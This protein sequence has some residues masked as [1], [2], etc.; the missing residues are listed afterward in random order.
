MS[1]E[2]QGSGVWHNSPTAGTYPCGDVKSLD[3]PGKS[4]SPITYKTID[5]VDKS[6]NAR[7]EFARLRQKQV[8]DEISFQLKKLELERQLAKAK[9]DAEIARLENGP[10]SSGR[11]VDEDIRINSNLNPRVDPLPLSEIIYKLELPKI[12]LPYFDGDSSTYHYFIREF[13]TQVESRVKQN[14]QRLSYLLH[15]CKGKRLCC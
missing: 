1:D 6:D 10:N 11:E 3:S 7:L 5:H 9:V 12:E 4:S 13:E 8:E 15:Y 14:N 2:N